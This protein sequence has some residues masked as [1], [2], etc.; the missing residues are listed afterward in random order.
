MRLLVRDVERAFSAARGTDEP[1]ALAIRQQLDHLR[2]RAQGDAGAAV[3]LLGEAACSAQRIHQWGVQQ[4][5]QDAPDLL[6]LLRVLRPFEPHSDS[7]ISLAES[8]GS[9]ATAP[10]TGSQHID[11]YAG[12]PARGDAIQARA[13]VLG[14]IQATRQWFEVNEP[15]SPVAVLLKQAERMVGQRFCT[16]GRR[17]PA[18]TASEVGFAG[19]RTGAGRQ[20]E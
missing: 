14:H 10:P 15:S 7:V 12:L 3:R 4:L 11:L 18:R 20:G 19:L 8:A 1:D 17:H 6:P 16:V 2:I 5:Q 9:H 13:A